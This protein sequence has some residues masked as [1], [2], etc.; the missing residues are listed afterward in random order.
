MPALRSKKDGGETS[1]VYAVAPRRPSRDRRRPRA[2][3]APGRRDLRSRPSD[4]R[5]LGRSSEGRVTRYSGTRGREAARS[6]C[7]A[8][9]SA[10][11]SKTDP[12]PDMDGG[13]ASVRN[14]RSKC[15]CSHVL[16]FTFRRAV[17]C[18][19]HRP[20]SQVIHCTVLSLTLLLY[21]GCRACVCREPLARCCDGDSS[22]RQHGECCFGSGQFFSGGRASASARATGGRAPCPDAS[23]R[24]RPTALSPGPDG[25]PA[26][27]EQRGG[28]RGRLC[29]PRTKDPGGPG[30]CGRP[31][32]TTTTSAGSGPSPRG[33]FAP[34]AD[35]PERGAGRPTVRPSLGGTERTGRPRPGGTRR[36]DE[37][38]PKHS[39]DPTAGS[40]T[41]TLLRL[42]LPLNA[43]VWKSSRASGG[44]RPRKRPA[45]RGPVQMPH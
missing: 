22:R 2:G 30:E 41:V 44:G 35:G 39:N 43:Q 15:R 5:P 24:R 33:G 16:Q 34:P 19:L 32:G 20:P 29:E 18:V 9:A 12:E 23:A 8:R 6:Q 37:R 14:V 38:Y 27:R 4:A 28:I 26:A 40:P 31:P 7:R 36:S 42:L 11:R 17:C 1:A 10:R 45:P 21:F 25:A 13:R 3:T